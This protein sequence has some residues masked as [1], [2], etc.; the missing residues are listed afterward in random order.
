MYYATY[1]TTDSNSIIRKCHKDF[2]PLLRTVIDLGGSAE[3]TKNG[4]IQIRLG[5]RLTHVSG[6]PRDPRNDMANIKRLIRQYEADLAEGLDKRRD[7]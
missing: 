1:M 3:Q 7:D 4:H 5:S 2:R 6:T